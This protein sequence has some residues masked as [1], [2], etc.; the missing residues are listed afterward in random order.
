ML[1]ETFRDKFKDRKHVSLDNGW[2]KRSQP[3]PDALNQMSACI[4]ALLSAVMLLV[5]KYPEYRLLCTLTAPRRVMSACTSIG[6]HALP[7]CQVRWRKGGSHDSHADRL[8]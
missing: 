8:W 7:P 4:Q 1:R 3:W 5:L 6:V 2:E